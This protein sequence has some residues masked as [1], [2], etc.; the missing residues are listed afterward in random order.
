[1]K[2]LIDFQ[3][4]DWR[5][6][7]AGLA[8]TLAL[9]SV[10]ALY[11]WANKARMLASAKAIWSPFIRHSKTTRV[12][13]TTKHS[14]R[15]SGTAKVSLNE[16][17][18]FNALRENF[19]QFN[20]KVELVHS[21]DAHLQGM[22]G[23][24]ISIGGPSHNNVTREILAAALGRYRVL[25]FSY[26]EE[27][28]S[29]SMGGNIFASLLASDETLKKDYGL[30]L[31]VTGLQVDPSDSCLVAFGLRGL[32]TWGAVKALTIDK[33]TM[34]SVRSKVDGEDFAVLLE[35]DFQGNQ[36]VGTR[37]ISAQMLIPTK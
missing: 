2:E 23:H 36:L 30:I 34:D 12:V 13:L 9:Q 15:P 5:G 29:I 3:Y 14:D 7:L 31:R 16:V 25:P 19:S 11:K 28:R 22:N 10:Y 26:D 32:G 1:M 17:E 6:V 24:V 8:A 4:S 21:P 33:T 37:L 35:F 27:R 18:A 20:L